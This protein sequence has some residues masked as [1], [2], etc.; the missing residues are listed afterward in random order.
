MS[1]HHTR[2][3]AVGFTVKS[4]WASAVLVTGSAASPVV[5]KSERVELSDPDLPESRQPYHAGFGAARAPGRDLRR[6]VASVE[7]FG[8]CS[9]DR[10]LAACRT[11]GFEVRGAGLVVGSLI[12]PATIG[13]DHIRIHALEGRLF[14]R[15]VAAA[16]GRSGVACSIWRER[17]LPGIAT[18]AFRRP[19]QELRR[20]LTALGRE[21]AGSWRAEQKL[22]TLAGWLVLA[23]RRGTPPDLS[24]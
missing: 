2:R 1:A 3:A 12:D 16:A 19:D 17:D 18:A 6:L 22:A 8:G 9:V 15:V 10:L 23:G 24:N 13:N 5:V 20:T 14:R 21:I 4:G 7:R 11:D